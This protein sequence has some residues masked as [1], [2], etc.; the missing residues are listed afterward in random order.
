MKQEDEKG[1][2][3]EMKWGNCACL[4]WGV[5]I[6]QIVLRGKL[7]IE[8]CPVPNIWLYKKS[9]IVQEN[10]SENNFFLCRTRGEKKKRKW[11]YITRLENIRFIN[12][13]RLYFHSQ[14]RKAWA[15][16]SGVMVTKLVSVEQLQPSW[17][18]TGCSINSTLWHI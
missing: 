15:S 5:K 4:H 13:E 11:T 10:E 17:I 6:C 7:A 3:P 14:K 9:K 12:I 18:L 16:R 1:D 8:N 2:T